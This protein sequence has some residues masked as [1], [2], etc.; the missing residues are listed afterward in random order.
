MDYQDRRQLKASDIPRVLLGFALVLVL[1]PWVFPPSHP[2]LAREQLQPLAGTFHRIEHT[3]SDPHDAER[4]GP[5]GSSSHWVN[6]VFYIPG[7]VELYVEFGTQLREFSLDN[8]QASRYAG[9]ETLHPGDDVSLLVEPMPSGK[10]R[11]WELKRGN[12]TIVDYADTRAYV[13]RV[14]GN[15]P[16]SYRLIAFL[17]M[18]AAALAARFLPKPPPP[19]PR[20]PPAPRSTPHEN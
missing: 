3:E 1:W 4:Q 14:Y 5:S 9:L 12:E 7:S 16:F 19:P 18:L 20:E 2:L 6:D 15:T 10:D 11:L 17:L 8:R 13:G